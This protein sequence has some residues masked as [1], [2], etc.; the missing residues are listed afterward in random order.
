[1]KIYFQQFSVNSQNKKN[2]KTKET[3]EDKEIVKQIKELKEWNFS[4]CNH[5][6][7][8]IALLYI[9]IKYHKALIYK[10]LH[11][12]FCWIYQVY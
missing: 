5:N 10:W 6:L 12:S 8:K 4:I 11:L 3:E 2:Y 7:T 9:L 1:M